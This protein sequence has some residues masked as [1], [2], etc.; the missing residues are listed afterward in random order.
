MKSYEYVAIEVQQRPDAGA[1][2]LMQSTP[3]DILKWASVPR[4]K[5]EFQLG[6]QRKLEDRHKNI[7]EYLEFAPSNIMPTAILIAANQHVAVKD[8]LVEGSVVPGVKRIIF[9]VDTDVKQETLLRLAYEGLLA[10]LGELER[11]YVSAD[12]NGNGSGDLGGGEEEDDDSLVPPDSYVAIIARQFKKAVNNPASVDPERMLVLLEYAKTMHLPA[13]ILDGQHRVYGA[14]LVNQFDVKLPIVLI[15][16]AG[17]AEQA[18]HFY[19]VNNKSKPLTP[20]ELRGT[21]ST[22]LTDREIEDLY[23]R[24]KQAGVSADSARWTHLLN[25]S[26]DSPFKGL[27]D[28]GFGQGFLKENAMFQIVSRFMRPKKAHRTVFANVKQWEDDAYRLE[29]FF[30]F[31]NTIKERYASAWDSAIAANRGQLL[32]KATM[33]VVQNYVFD[34]FAS[35]MPKRIRKSQESPITDPSEFRSSV[36]DELHFLPEEFFTR[37][38]N[39]TDID[40]SDGKAMLQEQITKVIQSQGKNIGN[41]QLFKTSK[42]DSSS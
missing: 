6:Y 40:T 34:Q 23:R 25:T 5:Q 39:R 2:Y 7:Q 30:C 37:A 27:I 19:V 15:V 31:W 29:L 20:T 21:V 22:S 33:L 4:K 11:E 24:F 17:L 16:G 8:Y 1:F 41:M 3:S 18:F 13:M 10:R 28:F 35:D 9:S 36:E 38:W 26:D 42:S 32:F 14:K 12:T